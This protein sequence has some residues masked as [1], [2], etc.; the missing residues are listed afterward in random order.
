MFTGEGSI[1]ARNLFSIRS[2]RMRQF[3]TVLK[4]PI[5]NLWRRCRPLPAVKSKTTSQSME[6]RICIIFIGRT[7]RFYDD[8]ELFTFIGDGRLS[9]D[10]FRSVEIYFL[11]RAL[12]NKKH[13]TKKYN[14]QDNSGM[15]LFSNYST[16]R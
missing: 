7:S 6:D 14:L 11:L 16:G 2:E 8:A 4:C 12:T 9:A 13:K 15:I 10:A 5:A 1:T 3:A